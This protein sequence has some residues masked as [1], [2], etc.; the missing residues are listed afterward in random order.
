MLV[1]IE[2]RSFHCALI[3]GPSR[4]GLPIIDGSTSCNSDLR[5]VI[6]G[7]LVAYTLH[8]REKGQPWEMNSCDEMTSCEMNCDAVLDSNLE[9]FP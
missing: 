5:A 8:Q 7:F 9:P 3:Q 1:I 4:R 6:S 2:V